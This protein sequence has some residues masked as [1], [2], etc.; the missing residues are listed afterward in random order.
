MMVLV[1]AIPLP[2]DVADEMTMQLGM[3]VII[4]VLLFSAVV[5]LFNVFFL[6]K[7]VKSLSVIKHA[8]EK[9]S[10]SGTLS[11]SLPILLY[12]LGGVNGLAI[13]SGDLASGAIGVSYIC[14]A[15][16]LQNLQKEIDDLIKQTTL[17][18]L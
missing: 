11:K 14:I 2:E 10:F 18:Q 5:L 3:G 1:S 17:N 15:I 13:F 9:L 4:G 12:I 6:S 16:T 8:C 7:T